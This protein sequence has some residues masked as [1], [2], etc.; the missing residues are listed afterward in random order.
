MASYTG[1]AVVTSAKITFAGTA[2]DCKSIPS[3][4][5]ETC[6]PPN[7]T[8]LTDI[9][10]RFDSAA[11]TEDGEIQ[12]VVAGSHPALN[13]VGSLTISLNV[14]VAGATAT[15]SDVSVGNCIVTG[16]EPSTIEAGGDRVLTWTVTFKPNG[17]RT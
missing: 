14:S 8:D 17:S 16:V 9:E 2:Y 13:A 1:K 7:V 12:A 3:G 15:S 5:P 10:Q 4:I 6:E 11:V